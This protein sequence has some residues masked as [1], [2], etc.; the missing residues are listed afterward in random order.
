MEDSLFPVS[1][2][3]RWFDGYTHDFVP[4]FVNPAIAGLLG[5]AVVAGGAALGRTV[6]LRGR[7][8]VRVTKS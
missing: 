6:P 1:S 5:L 8:T 2:V 3:C 7:G 4:A